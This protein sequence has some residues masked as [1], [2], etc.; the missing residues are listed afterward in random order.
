MLLGCWEPRMLPGRG[1]GGARVRP[2]LGHSCEPEAQH[3]ARP[4]SRVH[5]LGHPRPPPPSSEE[6]WT[7]RN[8][9][10]VP[11]AAGRPRRPCWLLLGASAV[12][13]FK[14]G[15]RS[16]ARVPSGLWLGPDESSAAKPI[17]SCCGNVR[18]SSLPLRDREKWDRI[19][20]GT[21]RTPESDVTPR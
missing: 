5:C 1:R 20:K 19:N 4:S 6:P 16:L 7:P 3:A 15:S 11:E 9:V 12:A 8:S 21:V 13:S 14:L 17:M 18:H 2:A 10:W